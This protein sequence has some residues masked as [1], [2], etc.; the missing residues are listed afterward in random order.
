MRL[1][2]EASLG[3]GMLIGLQ[4]V[5]AICAIVLLDRMTPAIGRILDENVASKAA[6][7]EMLAVLAETTESAPGS[8]AEARFVR[9]LERAIANITEDEEKELVEDIQRDAL[10]VFRGD[11]EARQ[12]VVA[13]LQ[14]LGDVNRQSMI[15][16]DGRAK[17]LG[18]TGA[19][20]A[21]ILGA[22][23]L[24]LGI[25]AYRRL[26]LR[27]ELPIEAVRR[28][29]DQVRHDNSQAR[30]PTLLRAPVE[31]AQV[32]S[33]LNW[34]LDAWQAEVAAT[35]P[36]ASVEA[37]EL[38]S[39]LVWALDRQHAPVCILDAEGQVIA[40][41]QAAI[42]IE[43]PRVW[44]SGETEQ[45]AGWIVEPIPHST[46]HV[47]RQRLATE[48]RPIPEPSGKV[49]RGPAAAGGEQAEATSP[50]PT[51]TARP[52]PEG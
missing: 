5:L 31:I 7:E 48:P 36:A 44:R 19:W 16:A 9:A 39:A 40:L 32:G 29:L 22:F 43:L 46:L 34:V 24:G 1:Q 25:F 52:T 3:M 47:A 11:L 41:S 10:A 26:R 37:N 12:R 17:L 50:T 13:A 14:R 42:E 35:H 38:R 33:Q 27:I 15:A 18:R 6:V 4:L 49:A 30:C 8:R 45:P 23:S 28:T 51:A 21:A 20:A 2:R